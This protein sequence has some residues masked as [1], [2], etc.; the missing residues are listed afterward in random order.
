M[1]ESLEKL[2]VCV[3]GG[4][5]RGEGEGGVIRSVKKIN[6]TSSFCVICVYLFLNIEDSFVMISGSC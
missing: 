6:K 1:C 3:C 5:G 2:C 4:G